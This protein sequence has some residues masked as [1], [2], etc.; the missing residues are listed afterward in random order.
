M[1]PVATPDTQHFG[2]STSKATEKDSN[3]FQKQ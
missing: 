2:I 1:F 3:N